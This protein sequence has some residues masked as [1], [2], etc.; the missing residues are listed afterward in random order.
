M[1]KRKGRQRKVV[2]D[3]G[4]QVKILAAKLRIE[5]IEFKITNGIVSEFEDLNRQ[6]RAAN[7]RLQALTARENYRSNSNGVYDPTLK[8][9]VN[10]NNNRYA[11]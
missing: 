3:N 7:I 9:T 11:N 5:E 6:L 8:V 1:S 10:Q 4:L 2:E